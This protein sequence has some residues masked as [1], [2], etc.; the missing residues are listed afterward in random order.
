MK[1]L[2]VT[3]LQ[4]GDFFFKREISNGD[5]SY[6]FVLAKDDESITIVNKNL[7][8]HKETI[9]DF[10]K[11][12]ESSKKMQY[13][14]CTDTEALPSFKKSLEEMEN[15]KASIEKKIDVAKKIIPL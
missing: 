7:I 14:H 12:V 13:F 11:I 9:K 3:E 2:N 1:N 6:H 4:Q 8:A 5:K 15:K 10:E